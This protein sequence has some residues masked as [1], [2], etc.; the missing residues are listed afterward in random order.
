[1]SVRVFSAVDAFLKPIKHFTFN[2]SHPVG[3][4]LYPFRE[5]AGRL[6]TR[7]VL[8]RIQNQLL[9]LPL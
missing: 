7:N 2:P 1:V 9:Q 5:L 8:G 6:E 4:K 3:A